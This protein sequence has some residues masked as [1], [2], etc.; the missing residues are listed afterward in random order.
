MEIL[1]YKIGVV[2]IVKIILFA[3]KQVQEEYLANAKK[4]S[5][6]IKYL[7]SVQDN[8]PKGEKL[9]ML[10]KEWLETFEGN[11]Q[12]IQMALQEYN[13]DITSEKLNKFFND[14]FLMSDMLQK[15]N[16]IMDEIIGTQDIEDKK[17]SV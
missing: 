5:T 17:K 16:S 6:D 2:P 3:R 12:I 8:T 4:I 9:D 10:V 15:I 1:G 11:T 7:Q 14:L 13:R